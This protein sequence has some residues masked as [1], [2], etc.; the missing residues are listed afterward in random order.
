MAGLLNIAR[1]SFPE[2]LRK[3]WGFKIGRIYDLMSTPCQNNN[4][5]IFVAAFF[6]GI[7][8]AIYTLNAHDCS[9][10]Q[11]DKGKNLWIPIGGRGGR[12]HGRG[13]TPTFDG[14]KKLPGDA[15]P[16]DS[17]WKQA[18]FKGGDL[19][20]RLGAKLLI[21]DAALDLGVNWMSNM[22]E[23]NGCQ[24]PPDCFGA[25]APLFVVYGDN[26][27]DHT[28]DIA[29]FPG[30]VGVAMGIGGFITTVPVGS[31][32]AMC[33]AP[34]EQFLSVPYVGPASVTTECF[35]S[36]TSNPVGGD[37]S[38]AGWSTNTGDTHTSML[39]AYFPGTH[40][41]FGWARLEEPGGDG[42]KGGQVSSSAI[43]TVSGERKS[44]LF[45]NG[46][47][48]P[49]SNFPITGTAPKPR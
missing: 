33:S 9:D 10:T 49:C 43:F 22:L 31:V 38:D 24:Q 40:G 3:Q 13:G 19:V 21:I 14:G 47:P 6:S 5:F 30:N 44:Q 35:N 16:I 36:S 39:E 23:W 34:T 29:A 32:I 15:P 37:V 8:E 7:P 4:F 20:Q 41:V 45:A 27:L 17:G 46:Q 1:D 28:C 18:M 12:R 2:K 26:G 11:W 48:D 25:G 42:T